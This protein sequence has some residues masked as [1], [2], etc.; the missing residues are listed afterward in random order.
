MLVLALYQ[1]GWI[2][3]VWA[4]DG[5]SIEV[6]YLLLR[7]RGPRRH[8][9]R[10]KKQKRRKTSV[11][12]WVRLLPE[13]LHALGKG[14]GFLN[15]HSQLRHLRLEGTIGT[16]D[17][18]STGIVW[19]SIEAFCGLLRLSVPG[20]ELAIAPDFVEQRV[21]LTLD[22]KIV[23]RMAVIL[24]TIIIV[25]WYIPKRRLWSLLR[26]QRRKTKKSTSPYARSKEAKVA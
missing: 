5:R 4:P 20:F 23:V 9:K 11:L 22:A 14:L 8:R 6:R 16:E 26:D 7:L 1:P 19:G 17:P 15:R 12:R 10:E 21:S 24:T 25:L 3:F 18:A 2:K 13:L